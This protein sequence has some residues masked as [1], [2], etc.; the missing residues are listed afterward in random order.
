[1]VV[2]D[3]AG[4]WFGRRGRDEP[5]PECLAWLPDRVRR[6]YAAT[7]PLLWAAGSVWQVG[8]PRHA[9]F[10][11][12]RMVFLSGDEGE[13]VCAYD[14]NDTDRFFDLGPDEA[15]WRVVD[16]GLAELLA[17]RSLLEIAH[18]PVSHRAVSAI[19]PA[20]LPDVVAGLTEITTCPWRPV[21]GLRIHLG[22]GVLVVSGFDRQDVAPFHHVDDALAVTVAVTR[23][24]K[25]DFLA[26]RE[27]PRPWRVLPSRSL[28]WVRAYA[29]ER[30]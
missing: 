25:A 16:A 7:S 23:P 24:E 10:A 21:P 5:M 14:A 4:Q 2:A 30:R 27:W 18:G 11:P 1:M 9:R 22:D 28:E 17:Q 12:D 19:P 15:G 6:T 29:E 20:P 3:V 8:T 13:W 26:D